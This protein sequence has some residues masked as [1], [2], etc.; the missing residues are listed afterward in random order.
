MADAYRAR[1]KAADAPDNKSNKHAKSG[2]G[3]V[4]KTSEAAWNNDDS[5]GSE[6]DSSEG[7][8]LEDEEN[9]A[10]QASLNFEWGGPNIRKKWHDAGVGTSVRV[11]IRKRAEDRGRILPFKRQ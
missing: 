7:E 2:N 4:E 9:D 6:Y 11:R 5:D 1:K 3:A 10:A 8:G